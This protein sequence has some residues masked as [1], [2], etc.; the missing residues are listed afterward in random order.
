MN[1]TELAQHIGDVMKSFIKN[2]FR[3][4]GIEFE[5]L[6]PGVE[7]IM[8]MIPAREYQHAWAI[9]ALSEFR[10]ARK[11]DS[12]GFQKEFHTA[13]CPG[14]FHLMRHGWIMRTYQD[15]II[16]TNGDMN[17]FSWQTP[18]D[19]RSFK[20]SHLLGDYIGSHSGKQLHAFMQKWPNNTINALVKIQSPWRCVVPKGYYLLEMPVPYLDENRFTTLHGVFSHEYGP[21]NL[22]PQ[23]MWHVPKGRELI[24]AGTPVAQYIL[25]PKK[26]IDMSI[27]AVESNQHEVA[28]ILRESRY[29]QN[30]N[31]SRKFYESQ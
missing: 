7:K 3:P 10:D 23:L 29:V 16:E 1:S 17:A 5:C 6:A 20:N 31:V 12:F 25:L 18:I 15:I 27:K 30:Y 14:I 8:P 28:M 13:K 9:R 4:K 2:I 26:Q 19:Q 21:A 24:R 22:N 11:K